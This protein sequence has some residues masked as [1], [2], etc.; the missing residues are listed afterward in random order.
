MKIYL[1][2]FDLAKPILRSLNV[3]KFSDFGLG[4]KVMNNGIPSENE[5]TMEG[6]DGQ[7]ITPETDRIDGYYIYKLTADGSNGVTYLVKCGGQKFT[8]TCSFVDEGCIEKSPEP[9]GLLG[10]GYLDFTTATSVPM[11]SATLTLADSGA[12]YK[13]I[14]PDALY[15]EWTSNRF[16]SGVASKIIKASEYLLVMN[17]T[18]GYDEMDDGN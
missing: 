13:I 15:A 2:T 18:G 11:A 6:Q 8:L 9:S 14:V 7:T 17:A 1:N 10:S 3:G 12:D 4:V 5:V 16:W